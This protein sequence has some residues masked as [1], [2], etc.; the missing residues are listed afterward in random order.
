V[1]AGS[2]GWTAWTGGAFAF[3]ACAVRA[4]FFPSRA[5]PSVESPPAG[6]ANAREV[7]VTARPTPR[8]NA[9]KHEE[10]FIS[11]LRNSE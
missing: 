5:A 1:G 6:A 2:V 9:G 3:F 10:R 11:G 4:G 8:I 7:L